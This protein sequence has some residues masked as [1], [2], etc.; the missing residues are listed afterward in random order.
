[1]KT[2]E[3]LNALKKEMHDVNSR[4]SELSE[5]E[6]K[7]VIGGHSETDFCD[8]PA[9]ICRECGLFMMGRCPGKK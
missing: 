2:K 8:I 1:M 4:L 7:Q 9:E 3:E 5:D 6:L